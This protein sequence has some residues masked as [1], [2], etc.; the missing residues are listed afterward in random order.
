VEILGTTLDREGVNSSIVEEPPQPSALHTAKEAY[1]NFESFINYFL[2]IQLGCAFLRDIAPSESG[3]ANIHAKRWRYL[4]CLQ[5]SVTLF[6]SLEHFN[7]ILLV[8]ANEY[9]KMESQD[10]PRYKIIHIWLITTKLF[11]SIDHKGSQTIWDQ[12]TDDFNNIVTIAESLVDHSTTSNDQGNKVRAEVCAGKMPSGR[13]FSFI[14]GIV[15]PLFLTTIQCRHSCIRRRA[16]QLLLSMQGRREGLWDASEAA[17]IARRAMEM[18]EAIRRPLHSLAV[19][20]TWATPAKDWAKTVTVVLGD[21][22]VEIMAVI[23]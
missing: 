7:S 20:P 13:R 21:R 10:A 1:T 22:D 14:L 16:Y 4:T 12:F 17:K 6:H 5:A 8:H 3:V 23:E 9:C 19:D 18:E 11:L 15:A 2:H